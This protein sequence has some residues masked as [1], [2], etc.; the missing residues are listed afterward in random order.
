MTF[1]T[2][3]LRENQHSLARER[4][5]EIE[6]TDFSFATEYNADL[7][8]IAR[9]TALDQRYFGRQTESI[10][11]S[12]RVEVVERVHDERKLTK[13]V[14]I[15]LRRFNV[16][17]NGIDASAFIECHRNFRSNLPDAKKQQL[18]LFEQNRITKS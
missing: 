12:S 2:L 10:D 5:I 14:D 16:A 11:V 13:V 3:L 4:E 18:N 9:R 8:Q 15:E 6:V 7:T 1:V 17:M